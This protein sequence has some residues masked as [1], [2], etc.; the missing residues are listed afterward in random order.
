M[1]DYRWNLQT[2]DFEYESPGRGG[3]MGMVTLHNAN[4]PELQKFHWFMMALHRHFEEPL[5]DLKVHN[6]IRIMKQGCR[7]VA[8]YIEEFRDFTCPRDWPEDILVIWFKDGL[9]YD[10]YTTCLAQGAPNHLH[11]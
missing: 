9:N 8:E 1:Q 7:L 2:S 6:P 11:K 3:C 5:A 4:A 10:L